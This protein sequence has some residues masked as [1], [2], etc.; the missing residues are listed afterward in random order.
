MTDK[1]K[2]SEEIDREAEFYATGSGRASFP[3]TVEMRAFSSGAQWADSTNPA[4]EFWKQQCERLA[5]SLSDLFDMMERG[6]IV[7]ETANDHKSDWMTAA[8]EVT[9]TLKKADN[10][11]TAHREAVAKRAH[12]AGEE[13]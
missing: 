12:D 2:R 1:R 11:L 5:G 10:N 6:L 7:R 13:K 4:V 3:D 8:L 9:M